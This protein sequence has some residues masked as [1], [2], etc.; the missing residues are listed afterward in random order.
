MEDKKDFDKQTVFKEEKANH[1]ETVDNEANSTAIGLDENIAGLICYVFTFVSGIIML[2][3]E[4]ENEFVRFHAMQS[5]ILFGSYFI[6]S[7][8]LGFIPIIGLLISILMVPVAIVI[9]V[10][11]GYQAYKGKKFKFPIVGNMAEQLLSK[12]S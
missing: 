6:A 12:N 2:L 9:V 1:E 4:K 7:M 8:I 11:L 3:V 5:T 10:I